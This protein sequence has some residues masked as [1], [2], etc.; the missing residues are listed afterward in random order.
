MAEVKPKTVGE[1][2]YW[3]YA[4]LVMAW[5]SHIRGDSSYEKLHYIIRRK[6]YYGLLRGTTKIGSFLKDEKRKLSLSS[7]CSYCGS[8][9][10]LTLD[11]M[12]PR[13]KSGPHSA[14]NLVVACRSCN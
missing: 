10:D 5:V 12:I 4:N 11:H 7:F 14:D 8:Q 13:M 9:D 2:L 6:T 3:S 1:S